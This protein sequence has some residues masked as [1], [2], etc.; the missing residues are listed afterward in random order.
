MTRSTRSAADPDGVGPDERGAGVIATVAGVTVFLVLLLFAVQTLVGLYATSVVTA[1]TYDAAKV[2]AGAD[3]GD[4]AV[5]RVNA[6][7]G[8]RSQLG[9]YGHK[10]AFSW[11][12]DA[13]TVRLRVQAPRPTLLPHSLVRGVGLSDIE[14]TVTV[15]VERVR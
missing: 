13:E 5:G 3:A 2:L 15:R 14:R 10:A 1:A 4:S 11:E 6:E 8:A 12:N 9:R 7:A